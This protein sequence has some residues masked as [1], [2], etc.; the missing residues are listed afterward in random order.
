MKAKLIK[1]QSRTGSG[2]VKPVDEYCRHSIDRIEEAIREHRLLSSQE[3]AKALEK[4]GI[5]NAAVGVAMSVV[6]TAAQGMP[7]VSTKRSLFKKN[8]QRP[9]SVVFDTDTVE[10]DGKVGTGDKELF[11]LNGGKSNTGNENNN[12]GGSDSEEEDEE[13]EPVPKKKKRM[14]R[15][16]RGRTKS[17]PSGRIWLK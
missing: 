12:T 10:G 4:H 9:G 14:L 2:D 6:R 3:K 7:G 5:G 11:I 15:E 13:I 1:E 16:D 17:K 8:L